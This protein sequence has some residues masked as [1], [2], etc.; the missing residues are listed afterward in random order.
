MYR[1]FIRLNFTKNDDKL[2]REFFH[3]VSLKA[4]MVILESLDLLAVNSNI[5]DDHP[6]LFS[7]R[8]E[9][10]LLNKYD[11]WHVFAYAWSLPDMN[12]L[13]RSID[14]LPYQG[15]DEVWQIIQ[16]DLQQKD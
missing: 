14:C 3:S 13:N 4:V 7:D 8:R 10:Q 16:K 11:N 1:N 15:K 2:F 6:F 9:W 5:P 12:K